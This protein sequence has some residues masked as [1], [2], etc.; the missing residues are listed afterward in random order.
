M[1]HKP[2]ISAHKKDLCN[3]PLWALSEHFSLPIGEAAKRLG[4]SSITLNRHADEWG[5]TVIR[6]SDRAR[7]FLISELDALAEGGKKLDA[8]TIRRAAS[9]GQNALEAIR[10]KSR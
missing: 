10:K 3:P 1:A 2:Y 9:K 7:F 6:R 4:V 8:D 5:L